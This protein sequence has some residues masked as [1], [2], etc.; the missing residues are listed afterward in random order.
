MI[1]P[2]CPLIDE[3]GMSDPH[4]L[5]RED[6]CYLFTGH[7]VGF[8]LADWVMPDWR[9]YRSED[10]RAWEHVGTIDPRDNY[11]GAGNTNCWAGDIVQRN[12]RF[13]WYF[14]NHNKETGVMVAS[15][16]EGPYVDALGG[17]LV[18]SFD[19]TLFV[20]DDGSP[21]I[22]YG[23][24]DY[25]I[26]RLKDSMIELAE[27]PRLIPVDRKGVFNIVDKNSLHKHNG[28]YYLSCSAAYATSMSLYG[29]YTYRGRVGIDCGLGTSFAHGDFFA[30]KGQWYHVWC[31]Y[32]DRSKDRIRDCFIAPVIY[33][34]DGAMRDDL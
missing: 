28:I 19:P 7:D 1:Q 17:P 34:A 13:Y 6:A 18:D 25:R 32:R 15:R 31:K 12:G 14:S 29:P 4:V 27:E 9:I 10:L 11:M 20:D 23:A 5:V 33:D 8:G 22:I 24:H 30:W 26:A 21:Y 2:K 16:P 3:A